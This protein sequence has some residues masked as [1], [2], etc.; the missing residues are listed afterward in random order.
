MVYKRATNLIFTK[1][2]ISLLF[3]FQHLIFNLRFTLRAA[4][5]EPAD[6]FNEFGSLINTMNADSRILNK[7]MLIGPSVASAWTP[8]QVWDTGFIDTYKD[9]LY[10]LSVQQ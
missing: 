9:H 1:S 10:C 8:E 6:Y 4:P 3:D 2:A 7:N 5:Y